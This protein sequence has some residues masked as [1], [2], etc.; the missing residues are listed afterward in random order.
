MSESDWRDLTPQQLDWAYDQTQHAPNM[1][2]VLTRCTERS[3]EARAQ[4]KAQGTQIHRM[5]YG[6]T[7]VE[8]LDWYPSQTQNATPNAPLVFFIHGGAW[9]RGQAQDHA[10]GVAWLLKR[11]AQVVVPDFAAVTEVSGRLLTLSEQ[12]QRA[13]SFTAK[14]A[15]AMGANPDRIY[16]VGHSS[17]AHLAACLA[18]HNWAQEGFSKTPIRALLC[19]S[20]MYELEPVSQSARSQY[21]A[22]TPQTL[23][24]LSPQRHL[25]AFTMPVVLL[26][27]DQE[28]PEFKRQA[29][30]FAQALTDQCTD[31][32]LHW[33][34]GLNHFEML[35]TFAQPDSV[36]SQA[37]QN[38]MQR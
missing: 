8:A 36:M 14:Q 31:L 30:E 5:A 9:R 3:A 20:G 17:G 10:M 1:A 15:A 11:G 19:C 4:V 27:G 26:C 24:A 33:G 37:L 29:R 16:V 34:V 35:E 25:G 32:S 38:L 12:V 21:V 7:A 13:L 22:F 18:T 23:Q 6:P 28:S 2:E